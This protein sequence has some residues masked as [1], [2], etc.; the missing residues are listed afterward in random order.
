MLYRF[1]LGD[2]TGLAIH[3]EV[4]PVTGRRFFAPLPEM[5]NG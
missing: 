4:L 3:D 2:L 5:V 1:Q